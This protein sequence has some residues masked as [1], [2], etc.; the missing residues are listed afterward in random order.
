MLGLVAANEPKATYPEFGREVSAAIKKA[1]LSSKDIE[2]E[3]GVT[4][5]AIRLWKKGQRM[6][7]DRTLRRLAKMLGVDVATLRYPTDAKGKPMPTGT[8]LHVTDE[9]E[10]HLI[11]AYRG[12]DKDWAKQALRQRAVELLEEF[13]KKG[14]TNPWAKS[15]TH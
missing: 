1:R 10:I 7:G 5:E 3:L 8:G 12:L 6:P 2:L 9:D 14:A 13:G 15:G 4:D 11:E